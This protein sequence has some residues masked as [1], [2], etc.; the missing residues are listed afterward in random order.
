MKT[1]QTL[2]VLLV[3]SVSVN[4]FIYLT[5]FQ[6]GGEIKGYA[7]AQTVSEQV[8]NEDINN[9]ASENGG[10]A[11]GII[12]GSAFSDIFGDP[13]S[14]AVAYRL[15]KDESGMVYIVLEGAHVV[16]ENGEIQSATMTGSSLYRA[17]NW[18]PPNCVNISRE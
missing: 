9:Y 7:P 16:E 10:T 3:L 8:A 1:K 6:S 13:N 4:I 11:G 12:S 18:C 17:N 5:A 2:T 14:N 15:A